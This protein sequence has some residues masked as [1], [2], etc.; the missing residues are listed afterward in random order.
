MTAWAACRGLTTW[1]KS[2]HGKANFNLARSLLRATYDVRDLF[3]FVRTRYVR[4]SELGSEVDD[5]DG[6]GTR[7][8]IDERHE[9]ALQNR[10]YRF[11]K[12]LSAMEVHVREAE[13]LWGPEAETAMADIR[14]LAEDVRFAHFEWLEIN[15]ERS[16]DDRRGSL[17]ERQEIS[18]RAFCTQE[19][20]DEYSVRMIALVQRMERIA[21][22]Y[23]RTRA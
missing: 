15:R 7:L 2:M 21:L 11:Y 6:G 20:D 12:A 17:K 5:A 23:L 1:R 4:G 19:R 13:V 9:R 18:S 3:W 10:M 8:T 22:P 16:P 14:R